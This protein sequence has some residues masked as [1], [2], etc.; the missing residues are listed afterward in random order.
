MKH[1]TLIATISLVALSGCDSAE[2]VQTPVPESTVTEQSMPD[3]AVEL[4]APDSQDPADLIASAIKL[5]NFKTLTVTPDGDVI[6]KPINPSL[7]DGW[8][9]VSVNGARVIDG[10]TVEVKYADGRESDRVRL[11]GIDAP[12]SKQKFGDVSKST[13]EECI[14]D[15][16]VTI[17]YKEID[18]YGRLL[19][20]V[21]AGSTDCNYRQMVAGSA[22]H[23][24][25]YANGQPNDDADIYADAEKVAQLLNQGLWSDINAQEPWSF[26]KEN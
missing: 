11:I 13:L 8:K 18:K 3:N 23:Y 15:K 9:R 19:G 20:K 16:P 14:G 1:L 7:A 24:K 22:W 10:D 5:G 6:G 2:E 26:R 17:T 12:E 21:F 4:V 25:Q